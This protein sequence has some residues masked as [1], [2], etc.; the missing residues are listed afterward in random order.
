MAGLSEVLPSDAALQTNRLG[1]IGK[2]LR[3]L[4]SGIRPR[5]DLFIRPSLLC[6]AWVEFVE[7]AL[8]CSFT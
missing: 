2:H 4:K 1:L 5:L 7:Q 8:V 6:T 3:L